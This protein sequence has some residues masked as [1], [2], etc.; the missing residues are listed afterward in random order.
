MKYVD[1]TKSTHPGYLYYKYRSATNMNALKS[2]F[3]DLAL[4]MNNKSDI[5]LESQ[6]SLYLNR[7]IVNVWFTDNQGREVS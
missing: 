3:A 5:P 6:P 1:Q 7:K 4:A 2:G